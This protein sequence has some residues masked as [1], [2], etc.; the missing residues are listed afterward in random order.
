MSDDRS[1]SGTAMRVVFGLM[2]VLIIGGLT[3]AMTSDSELASYLFDKVED[4]E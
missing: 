4:E 3:Y 2:A 1:K